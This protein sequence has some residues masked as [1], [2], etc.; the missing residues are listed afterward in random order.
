MTSSTERSH[1]Q[2]NHL[3]TVLSA[4]KLA[5]AGRQ[6]VVGCCVRF[7]S[8]HVWSFL[9][10]LMTEGVTFSTDTIGHF[11]KSL[12]SSLY[13]RQTALCRLFQEDFISVLS[14]AGWRCLMI[15]SG[16]LKAT[17]WGLRLTGMFDV[18]GWLS[19]DAADYPGRRRSRSNSEEEDVNKC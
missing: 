16:S 12:P 17:W 6:T 10:N 19:L 1:S 9:L 11:E 7:H 18:S 14:L 5:S 8:G 3:G 2:E 13:R 15:M 4:V